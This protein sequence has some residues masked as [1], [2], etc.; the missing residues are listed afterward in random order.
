MS[1]SVRDLAEFA[2]RSGDLYPPGSARTVDAEEGVRVQQE[3]QKHRVSAD[4]GYEREVHL[5][6]EC[7]INGKTLKLSGRADGRRQFTD[8]TLIEEFKCTGALPQEALT[9]DVGQTLLYAGLDAEGV[10]TTDGYRLSTVY[11]Q[12]DTLE[13]RA[14][15][16][17]M[18]AAEARWWLQLALLCYEVRHAVHRE[19][20]AD[21]TA[22]TTRMH[23]PHDGY[24]K[25]QQ[26]IARRVYLA[27]QKHEN[28]LLEAPTGSG[29]TLATL[30]PALKSI[31]DEQIFFLTSRNTGARAPLDAVRQI[32]PGQ[33]HIS[34]VEI[35]AKEKT[36]FVEGMP[37]D[38]EQCEFA[39]GYYDRRDIAVNELISNRLAN[40]ESIEHVARK[41]SVC[42]FELSL[43]TA[44][45]SDINVG[46]YNYIL[47]PFVQLKRFAQ[48]PDIHLFIDEAHQLAPRVREMLAALVSRSTVKTAL[49]SAPPNL[50][51]SV[52]SVNRALMKVRRTYAGT[53]CDDKSI[54]ALERAMER[55]IKAAGEH[56]VDL[57]QHA[58]FGEL[59]FQCTRWLKSR[60]WYADDEAALLVAEEP[61]GFRVTRSCL[62]PAGYM[63]ETFSGFGTVIRFSGT[64]S[65]LLLYQELHGG[66]LDARAERAESPFAP[67]QAGVFVIPD[68]P[69]YLRQRHKSADRLAKILIDL[70]TARAGRYLA[71]I[72]SFTYLDLIEDALQR[73]I[74]EH[75]LQLPLHRQLQGQDALSAEDTID[76]FK[77][78]QSGIFLVVMGGIFAE[79]VDFADLELAGV[80]IVGLGLPPPSTERDLIAE[81]FNTH[82]GEGWGELVAYTQPA[83]VKV[84]QAAGRLL[85]DPAHRGVICLIDD[86]FRRTDVQQF[87]PAFWRP[88]EV[89]SVNIGDRVESFW[90]S[91]E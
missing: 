34:I 88:E 26:A 77:R 16:L 21:R 54:A 38:S 2:F 44:V 67:G 25:S 17:E 19:H 51:P 32:D 4:P 1:L 18:D 78:T 72:P 47:D 10:A 73:K 66:D 39:R 81:H 91:L 86:R 41:H 58:D 27:M 62:D 3:V 7:Q 15:V 36:C 70:H 20:I 56:D 6:A 89:L 61:G 11:V 37:C 87:F 82:H 85:R 30:F 14:F 24:R 46:D 74:N 90:K 42:P 52:R 29:K 65:P 63:A 31:A 83:L 43:D 57:R 9:V 8:F 49:K 48:R 40:R 68:V 12:P 55:L 76:R 80:C 5:S 71:V 23:F 69:T 50:A 22:F 53:R 33:K 64:V 75:G 13:E 28:L 60:E 84:V 79:S 59:Y 35:T 45:W